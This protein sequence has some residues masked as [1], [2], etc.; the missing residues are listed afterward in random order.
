M[1]LG[2]L[3]H[4]IAWTFAIWGLLHGLGLAATHGF[5]SWRGRP[6]PI[7]QRKRALLVFAT[8]QFVC[9][10]WLF[11]RANSLANA[12][13]LLGRIASLTPGFDNLS[14]PLV[15]VM[16]LSAATL[17]ISKAWYSRI[18]EGFAQSPSYVHVAALFL[19]ALA[20]QF[21]GGRGSAPFVYSRF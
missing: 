2:G 3:W 11:F 21:L 10:T 7:G 6:K 18:M 12:Q 19:V 5:R 4:G 8:C 13:A 20:L 16:L 9:L 14:A 15:A 17:F 1:L